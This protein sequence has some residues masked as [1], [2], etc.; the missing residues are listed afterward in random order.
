MQTLVT[1]VA[2]APT[3]WTHRFVVGDHG[4]DPEPAGY[5]QNVGARHVGDGSGRQDRETGV[6]RHRIKRLPHEIES[7]V[8]EPRE[9]LRG[10]GQVELSHI[11]EQ[12]EGDAQGLG[13]ADGPFGW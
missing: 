11:R 6:G 4:V 1:Q 10:A 5:A 8:A 9:D 2:S 13:H 7:S 3:V 12:Q